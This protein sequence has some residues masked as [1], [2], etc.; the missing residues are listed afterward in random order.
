MKNPFQQI[1]KNRKKMLLRYISRA[2]ATG[3]TF[4]MLRSKHKSDWFRSKLQEVLR[5]GRALAR[6]MTDEHFDGHLIEAIRRLRKATG[7]REKERISF[8]HAA[9]LINLYVK[10]LA[11]H[12]DVIP[13]GI[14]KK[15]RKHAHVP[16]DRIILKRAM[17]DFPNCVSAL[18]IKRNTGVGQISEE[19]YKGL[20]SLLRGAAR[21]EGMEPLAYDLW[22]ADRD[23]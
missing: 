8:G 22:W 6:N 9:K 4:R 17:K 23:E 11:L 14:A 5:D 20:Q 12:R 13:N 10:A 3:S 1:K 18:G 2:F 21:K 19:Q 16:L 7:R 15:I